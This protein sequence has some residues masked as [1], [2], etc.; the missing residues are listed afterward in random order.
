MVAYMNL[1]VTLRLSVCCHMI[2][3]VTLGLRFVDAVGDNDDYSLMT[4]ERSEICPSIFN[5]EEIRCKIQET[6]RR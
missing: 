6:T 5:T 4:W 2:R 1:I 3:H